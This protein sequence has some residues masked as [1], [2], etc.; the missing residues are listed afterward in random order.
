MTSLAKQKRTYNWSGAGTPLL[1]RIDRWTAEQWASALARAQRHGIEATRESYRF[2]PGERS[3]SIYKV[4]SATRY[5]EPHTV[6]VGRRDD[7]L[8]VHCDCRDG[9]PD[10]APCQHMAA[11]L[12][13]NAWHW[14]PQ[15]APEDWPRCPKCRAPLRRSWL[16]RDHSHS[17]R[18]KCLPCNGLWW[19][20]ELREM[21]VSA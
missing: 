7:V 12:W 8:A 13:V 15:V 10:V 17:Y 16:P 19:E 3:L 9:W 11:A 18:L 1:T 21:G 4:A 5:R 2:L 6:H 14:V 20:D